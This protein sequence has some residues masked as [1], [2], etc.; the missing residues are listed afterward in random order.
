M[1]DV[2][3]V[4]TLQELLIRLEDQARS[5][6]LNATFALPVVRRINGVA[7]TFE[8]LEQPDGSDLVNP[9]FWVATAAKSSLDG[10]EAWASLELY[11]A[12]FLST[13]DLR[14]ELLYCYQLLQE[15][16]ITGE[17]L[18]RAIL[19][20]TRDQYTPDMAVTVEEESA[21]TLANMWEAGKIDYEKLVALLVDSG[22]NLTLRNMESLLEEQGLTNE[23]IAEA[24]AQALGLPGYVHG[25]IIPDMDGVALET[26]EK[27]RGLVIHD[28]NK[29]AIASADS[30]TEAK[31]AIAAELSVSAEELLVYA[32]TC[33]DLDRAIV[34][35]KPG[36]TDE[37]PTRNDKDVR[38]LDNL[39][40]LEEVKGQVIELM[41]VVR[42]N[43]LR[44]DA[45]LPVRVIAPHMVFSGNP[46]T[47]KT[48]VAKL[49]GAALHQAGVLARPDVHVVTSAELIGDGTNPAGT[50]LEACEAALGGILFIDEAYTLAG[51]NAVDGNSPDRNGEVSIDTLLKY[52]EDHRGELMVIVAGYV[53]EMDRFI[54]A[55]R[56]LEERFDRVMLFRDYDDEQLAEI[57]K[58]ICE[59][60]GYTVTERVLELAREVLSRK[61]DTR[62]FANARTV[63]KLFE[64]SI[65][66]QHQRLAELEE[67][68]ELQQLM[69]ITADDL[70]QEEVRA[71]HA[72]E[73]LED[74]V[75]LGSVK[76]EVQGLIASVSVAKLRQEAGLSTKQIIPHMV[77]T[78]KSGT[79][80]T[81]VARVMGEVFK[82]LG[83]LPS[84]H[85]VEVTRAD[86]V[87]I[88]VG[89]T[90]TKTLEVCQRALGG[91]LFIDEAYTLHE[92]SMEHNFGQESIDTIL[93]FMEDNR[94]R[95][96]VV[97]AGY[98]DEMRRFLQSNPGL[99]SRFDSVI[100]FPNYTP[101]EMLEIFERLCR[102]E[103]Y[104]L[105][106]KGTDVLLSRLTEAIGVEG[107]ANGRTVRKLFEEAKLSQSRRLSGDTTPTPE[108][109]TTF[110]ASDLQAQQ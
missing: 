28:G 27:V 47:G 105:N 13:D 14:Q 63:R 89:Q 106:Q 54:R 83:L 16:G 82:E 107:F 5:G 29:R 45:G 49:L 58:S 33:R 109:L 43:T 46:G 48:T 1:R 101:A 61:R 77:F 37:V 20:R 59:Q 92:K 24:K 32:V 26:A 21:L 56:G 19:W 88:Y 93:K 95:F 52:M 72:A 69:E 8:K 36:N 42:V 17:P 25:E 31:I 15:E 38:T 86:L 71:K 70:P 53:A 2:S 84:G 87:A 65:V 67:D 90:A 11:I 75:G 73:L 18:A 10:N 9:W 39:I 100:N 7:S 34:R 30:G 51:R 62:S 57:F 110:L 99:K 40:G 6:Q 4:A 35:A 97:A 79:G 85:V 74:L 96:V 23:E 68:L 102:K 64:Q 50:T 94:G 104:R 66:K 91:V 60:E 41:A 55:N 80:K 22:G 78:G 76:D 98:E 81:T 3:A 103:N 44:Q 108:D 12:A